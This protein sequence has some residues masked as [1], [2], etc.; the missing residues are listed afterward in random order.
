MVKSDIVDKNYDL[1]PLERYASLIGDPYSN[2]IIEIYSSL[3]HN[4]EW[5][6]K[7]ILELFLDFQCEYQYQLDIT[8]NYRSTIFIREQLRT[9]ETII[10]FMETDFY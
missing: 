5:S 8:K 4:N 1:T 7:Q 3:Q 2:S 9:L 6:D 10:T